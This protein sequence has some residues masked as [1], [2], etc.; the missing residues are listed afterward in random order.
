MSA[1]LNND[2]VGNENYITYVDTDASKLVCYKGRAL[3]MTGIPYTP[4]AY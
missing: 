1:V 4:P 3:M 2:C